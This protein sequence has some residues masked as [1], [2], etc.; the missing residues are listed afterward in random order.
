MKKTGKILCVLAVLCLLPFGAALPESLPKEETDT[1]RTG[2]EQG[3]SELKPLIEISDVTETE[4]MSLEEVTEAATNSS[5]SEYADG[6][7]GFTM[8]YPAVFVFDEEEEGMVAHTADR[9]A[10]LVIENMPNAGGLTHDTLME[11]FTQIPEAE[12]QKNE[13]NG[14]I[15]VDSIAEDGSSCQT[16]LYFLTDKSFHH[17]MLVYPAEERETYHAYIEFM[18]NSMGTNTTDQG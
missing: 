6:A 12:P 13:Q 16:D 18:V 8:H 2:E 9:S 14:C 4:G 1:V 7:T 15:R 5:M 10:T 17:I 11:A 3:L